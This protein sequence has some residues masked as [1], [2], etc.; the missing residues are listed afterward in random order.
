MENNYENYSNFNEVRE[1]KTNLKTGDIVIVDYKNVRLGY[2]QQYVSIVKNITIN[3]QNH[4]YT[5]KLDNF[6]ID[7]ELYNSTISCS[8]ISASYAKE[9]IYAYIYTIE[10]YK[11]AINH[12]FNKHTDNLKNY[13]RILKEAIKLKKQI[14]QKQ[15][16]I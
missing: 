1:F 10:D 6:N 12:Y 15:Y 7:F 3:E 5:C 9:D 2:N 8:I 13:K 14:E 11:L 16:A 4:I